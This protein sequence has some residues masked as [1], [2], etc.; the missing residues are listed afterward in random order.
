MNKRTI[1]GA[2]VFLLVLLLAGCGRSAGPS[3][4]AGASSGGGYTIKDPNV[5]P[6]GVFPVVKEPVTLSIG[7]AVFLQVS[8]YYQ[9]DLTKYLEDLTGV[10]LNF[11]LYDAGNDGTTKLGLQ[12]AAG[13]TLPDLIFKL[14]I[15]DAAR[16][17]AYGEAGAIIPLNEYLENL[18]SYTRNAV[19]KLEV[20]NQ[21]G[22][23]PWVYGKDEDGNIW[24]YMSYASTFANA[25]SARAW[26]NV[27]FAEK[28][29]MSEDQWT[30]GGGKG[31]IPTQE[32]FLR[33]LRGVRDNDVNGNGDRGDE[34]PLTGH[35]G[36]RGSMLKWLCNQFLFMDYSS[37]ERFW[38]MKNGELNFS[39]D[40]PEYRDALRFMNQLY[41][42]KLFDESAITQGSLAAIQN[43]E[44]PL[45]GVAVGAGSGANDPRRRSYKSISIVEGPAEPHNVFLMQTPEFTWAI[46][47]DC[48][49]PEAAFRFLDAQASDPDFAVFPRYGLKGR[50]WRP[51]Q[52]GEVGL[53]GDAAPTEPYVVELIPV[54]GET[55]SS[56]WRDEFGIDFM[57]RKSS[58]AWNGDPGN[59]EYLYGLA[60]QSMVPFTPDEYPIMPV[61]TGAEISQYA[62]MR[63]N[64]HNYVNQCMAQFATGQMDPERDW[65]AYVSNLKRLGA[66]ELLELDRRAMARIRSR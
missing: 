8:D 38:Y 32:W 16:R 52:P 19:S 54:W 65:D 60:I 39:F 41:R 51:I 10:K 14:G 53:Y 64:V 46:T 47:K 49:Y 43:G 12:V 13:D 31:R 33:Y 28:L 58:L 55:L 21:Q 44:F 15:P 9:N 66:D 57:N 26:Y 24:A 40:K 7:L 27:D 36:W 3:V 11:V 42:E 61:Y 56:H 63:T 37:T 1:K 59:S 48:K 34:I 18:S 5:N 20:F 23:D 17:Q 30:G 22:I 29:G 45:A 6:D 25:N 62:E 4:S 50:D 35:S 2:A